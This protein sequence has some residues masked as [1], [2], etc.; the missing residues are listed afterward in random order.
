MAAK[1]EQLK[2]LRGPTSPSEVKTRPGA[3]GMQLSYI[4]ARYVYD[5]LDD[6]IGPQNWQ[7]RF[8][9]D[10]KG[11]LKCGIGICVDSHSDNLGEWVWK[12]DVGTESKVEEEKGEHSDA[13]KRAAVLWGIARDLYDANSPARKASAPPAPKAPAYAWV[14]PKHGQSR[15]VP[16]GVAKKTGKPYSAFRVCGVDDCGEMAPRRTPDVSNDVAG[17]MPEE[18]GLAF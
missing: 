6:K 1:L 2:S 12:W 14:C 5:T 3:G 11:L 8:E 15:V 16:A 9:R 4:D 13:M 10:P 18:E 17:V 7:N